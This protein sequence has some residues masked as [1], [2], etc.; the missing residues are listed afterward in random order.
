[1]R[2]G[3]SKKI[4]GTACGHAARGILFIFV[5]VINGKERAKAGCGAEKI[6]SL[7]EELSGKKNQ[8]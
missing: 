3:G 1:M 7:G 6:M 2:T 5:S 4:G 8:S